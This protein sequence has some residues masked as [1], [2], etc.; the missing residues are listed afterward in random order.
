MRRLL[1][2]VLALFVAACGSQQ[3]PADE[4][5][6]TEEPY[7][8]TESSEPRLGE[9]ESLISQ[10]KLEIK[11]RDYDEA[12]V[13]LHQVFRRDRWNPE[14]NTIYQDL[15]IS[16]GK[17]DALYQEYLDLYEANKTRGDALWFHL[18]PLLIKRGIK[19]CEVETYKEFDEP[20][21]RE[22]K[23]II[24][25]DIKRPETST[26]IM[27]R[28]LK[29]AVLDLLK[30]ATPPIHFPLID[31][32]PV[33]F[34]NELLTIYEEF[35]SEKPQSGDAV[36]LLALVLTTAK[37]G[38]QGELEALNLLRQSWILDLP[39]VYLRSGFADIACARWERKREP[40]SVPPVQQRFESGPAL[41]NIA[42]NF[43]RIAALS[44]PSGE[45]DAKIKRVHELAAKSE[46]VLED[47]SQ[48]D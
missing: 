48:R 47:L 9:I 15:Q 1:A 38:D 18:R 17:G 21:Q 14:A 6:F 19:A 33:K 22:L 40:G 11:R 24:E 39:G 27:I 42:L 43:Y 5:D 34:R 16:S 32:V 2:V 23:I 8:P 13:K 35:A 37:P 31:A 25:S 36:F 3:R 10:A 20:R 46:I 29:D 4:P 45:L 7:T 41:L 30:V 44:A 28:D 12:R 26:A